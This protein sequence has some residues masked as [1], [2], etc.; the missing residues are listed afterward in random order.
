MYTLHQTEGV[1]YYIGQL[2]NKF[3]ISAGTTVYKDTTDVS[4]KLALISSY[5][6]EIRGWA[7]LFPFPS[8]DFGWFEFLFQ[9]GLG[10]LK[11]KIQFCTVA[12][13]QFSSHI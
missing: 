2:T 5:I 6:N 7:N 4:N 8:K 12:V 10:S 9:S 3:L 1:C 13:G 11:I